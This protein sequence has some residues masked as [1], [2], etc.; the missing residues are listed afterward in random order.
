VLDTVKLDNDSAPNLPELLLWKFLLL[1]YHHSHILATAFD[2]TSFSTMAFFGATHFFYS[3]AIFWIRFTSFCNCMLQSWYT[4]ING[5]CYLSS[6]FFMQTDICS[7]LHVY[8]AYFSKNCIYFVHVNDCR[9]P[10]SK[11]DPCGFRLIA[12][13]RTNN[14]SCTCIRPTHHAEWS[15]TLVNTRFNTGLFL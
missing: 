7:A 12:W 2:F 5:C 10:K 3:W 9:L 6:V 11:H 13:M 1:A 14:H 15:I 8:H 4:A